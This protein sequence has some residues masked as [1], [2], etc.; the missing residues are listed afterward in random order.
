MGIVLYLLLLSLLMA[1]VVSAQDG[2]P[3]DDQGALTLAIVLAFVG[4]LERLMEVLKPSINVVATR[5]N[6]G[7]QGYNALV[8]AVSVILGIVGVLASNQQL[9]ILASLPLIPP[10]V[11]TV[12]TG[13]AAGFGS[14]IVHAVFDYA[15][16]SK[17]KTNATTLAVMASGYTPV[18][19]PSPTERK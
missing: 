9:N 1:S 12:L 6:L 14:G 17:Q 15:N 4:G 8:V 10:I 3:A 19:P 13:A 18:P 5:L 2:T 7:D 11:G 16:S